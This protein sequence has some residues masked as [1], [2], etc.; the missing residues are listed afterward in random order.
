MNRRLLDAVQAVIRQGLAVNV[1]GPC[2]DGKLNPEWLRARAANITAA[3]CGEFDI[4][5]RVDNTRPD[6]TLDDGAIT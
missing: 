5:P 3:L 6:P 2:L 1:P 4:R